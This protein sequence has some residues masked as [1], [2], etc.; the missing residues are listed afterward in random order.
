MISDPVTLAALA[1]VA[2]IAAI[3]TWIVA[4]LV[5]RRFAGRLLLAGLCSTLAAPL[6]TAAIGWMTFAIDVSRHPRSDMTAMALAG[7]LLIAASMPV[8]TG[9]VAFAVLLC[10]RRRHARSGPA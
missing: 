9:P 10:T 4:T 3:A 8:V 1:R 2:T 7:W 6:A 5:G